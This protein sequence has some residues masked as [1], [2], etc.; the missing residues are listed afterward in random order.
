MT[1]TGETRITRRKNVALQISHG[2]TW[3]LKG[4]FRGKRPVTYRLSHGMIFKSGINLNI[5]LVPRR[6]QFFLSDKTSLLMLHRKRHVMLF[7]SE[8]NRKH[9]HNV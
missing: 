3:G 7:Y 4:C 9:T 1:L 5:Q 6:K 2:P 8:I